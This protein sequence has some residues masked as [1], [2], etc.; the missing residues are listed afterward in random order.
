V[1]RSAWWGAG[2]YAGEFWRPLALCGG[3]GFRER[4]GG[5]AGE[6]LWVGVGWGQWCSALMAAAGAWCGA[7]PGPLWCVGWVV[8]HTW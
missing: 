5:G 6:P 7:R 4:G 1:V 2:A 8:R 3:W